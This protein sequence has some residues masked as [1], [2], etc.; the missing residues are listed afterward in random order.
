MSENAVKLAVV[1][2]YFAVLM[3]LGWLAHRRIRSIEDFYVAG[4]KLGYWVVAFSARA[5][6][7][8]MSPTPTITTRLNRCV[9]LIRHAPRRPRRA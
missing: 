8:P 2:V 5:S 3:A 7:P 1:I 9:P 6:E 4:K